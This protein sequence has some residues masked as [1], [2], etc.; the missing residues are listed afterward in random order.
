[1]EETPMTN[2]E[3]SYRHGNDDTVD[4]DS[5]PRWVK[6]FGIIAIV[7]V[8]LVVIVLLASG[9]NPGRHSP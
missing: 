5:P 6:L 8:L 9:H 7:G 1:M 4:D 2:R 3:P